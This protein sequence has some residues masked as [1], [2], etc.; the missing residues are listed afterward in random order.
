MAIV[1]FFISAIYAYSPAFTTSFIDGNF[2]F[3]LLLLNNAYH[4]DDKL[5]FL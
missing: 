3:N 5:N 1:T 2:S 4:A